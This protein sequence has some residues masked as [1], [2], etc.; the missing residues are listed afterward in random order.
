MWHLYRALYILTVLFYLI[1]MTLCF[2]TLSCVFLLEAFTIFSA[3]KIA[4]GQTI[5]QTPLLQF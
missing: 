1:V 5:F 2:L 4:K 3:L